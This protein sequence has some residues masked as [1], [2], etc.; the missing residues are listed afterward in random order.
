MRRS[1]PTVSFKLAVP[2]DTPIGLAVVDAK[3]RAFQTPQLDQV[4]LANAEPAMVATARGVARRSI[5]GTG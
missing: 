5:P 1:N 3:G 4:A 2:A